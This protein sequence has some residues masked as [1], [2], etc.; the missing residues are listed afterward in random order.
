MLISDLEVEY[1]TSKISIKQA[2]QSPQM[3]E[4]GDSGLDAFSGAHCSEKNFYQ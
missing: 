2:D 1:E 3:T 4:D